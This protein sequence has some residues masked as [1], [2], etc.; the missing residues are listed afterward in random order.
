MRIDTLTDILSKAG[1]SLETLHLEMVYELDGAA[2][3][4]C[5]T[6]YISTDAW[7]R[8]TRICND[9]YSQGRL[10]GMYM[11]NLDRLTVILPPSKLT[12]QSGMK[13]DGVLDVAT[14]APIL[15]CR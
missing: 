3:G 15:S 7:Q 11:P 9:F 1:K 8:K 6:M 10:I 12:T 4:E 5:S 13:L 2:V 14:K